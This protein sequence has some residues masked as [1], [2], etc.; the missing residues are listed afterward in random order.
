MAAAGSTTAGTNAYAT[1]NGQGHPGNFPGDDV[2]DH[3]DG[4]ED[5]LSGEGE[6]YES[7]AGEEEGDDFAATTPAGKR[8]VG[9]GYV[10]G[11]DGGVA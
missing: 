9:D 6:R 11:G 2:D 1:G 4:S 5:G 7:E 3:N 10:G 8:W